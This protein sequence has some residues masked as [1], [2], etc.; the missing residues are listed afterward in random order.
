MQNHSNRHSRATPESV[1]SPESVTLSIDNLTVSYGTRKVL[2]NA[3]ITPVETG[4][5]AGIIGP[6]ATGKSTL[7]KTI[8]G[9]K[10]ADDGKVTLSVNGQALSSKAKKS[11]IGYVPQ[12]F[13]SSAALTAFESVL[14]AA[15]RHTSTHNRLLLSIGKEPLHAVAAVLERLGITHLSDRYIGELSGGQR[16]LIA[17]AQMLVRQPAVMLLDEPTSALDLRHQVELLQ[18]I[19]HEVATRSCLALVAIHDLNLAARYCDYLIVLSGQHIAAEGRPKD[20][21]SSE[22][23]EEVYGFRA[24]VLDDQGTPVVSPV[25]S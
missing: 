8:A 10:K 6:N 18:T 20:I 1:S 16:Q 3:T 24:R 13:L 9:I 15:R 11:A 5:I 4:T 2:S 25:V 23:L 14:I 17:I 12:D 21:I 22:L 19:R 7:L